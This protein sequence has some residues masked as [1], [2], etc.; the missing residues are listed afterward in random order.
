M[1]TDEE[2]RVKSFAI[3][4]NVRPVGATHYLAQ[5]TPW[6]NVRGVDMRPEGT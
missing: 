2:L 6:G 3:R 4:F 1:E 5:G